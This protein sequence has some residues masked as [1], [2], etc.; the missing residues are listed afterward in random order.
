M[1]LY[2]IVIILCMLACG[3]TQN[4]APL[5]PSQPE[6]SGKARYL[7][8]GDSYTIGQSVAP[9]ERW[10]VI[11][12]NEL[13]DGGK[14]I[15]TPQIV[16]RTGWTTRN[17]LDALEQ[18]P[19]TG[20]FDLVSLLIGV[21]NQYQGRN[22]EE[23]R[24][25]FRQLLQ[26]SITYAGG[27]AGNVFVLSIPD[28]G[29]TAMGEG[30]RDHIAAEIDSFNAIAKDECDKL[31]IVFIDITGISRKALNDPTMIASDQLHF[32]GKMYRLWV[33]DVILEVRKLF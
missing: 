18:S 7:A 11:L 16:A 6:E 13:E 17:L 25:E 32:S 33:N 12:A 10:P 22:K 8:L 2:Q 27:D 4:P 23:Y 14:S 28:W 21:N 30:N 26:K 31:K 19:P 29:V 5:V 9:D 24:I 15:A 1:K 20:T 3:G